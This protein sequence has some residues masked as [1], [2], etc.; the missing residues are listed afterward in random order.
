MVFV[1][2][3]F[4][5]PPML[6]NET[7]ETR[8]EQAGDDLAAAQY[9]EALQQHDEALEARRA[10]AYQLLEAR[11]NGSADPSELREANRAVEVARRDGI[12]A[13]ELAG[14]GRPYD[15]TNYVFLTFVTTYFPVGGRR[16]HHCRHLRGCHVHYLGGA[17]FARHNEHDRHLPTS[18]PP[19]RK[20]ASLRPDCENR[21]GV[22]G[23][24]CPPPSHFSA[25]AS[26]P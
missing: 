6:F 3:Q 13:V 20:R 9:R 22:L 23:S 10:A 26:A 12:A 17:Q 21:Y 8:I 19:Q 1:F 15:D 5:A 25:G 18:L 16:P 24:L 14:D 4:E 2:Y 7:A 11:R